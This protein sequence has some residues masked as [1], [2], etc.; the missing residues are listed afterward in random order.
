MRVTF[1]VTYTNNTI[2]K[3]RVTFDVTYTN[4]TI[5]KLL[6]CN[7]G[8]SLLLMVSAAF[9][10]GSCIGDLPPRADPPGFQ[11]L[12]EDDFTGTSLNPKYWNVLDGYVQTQYDISC[13]TADNAYVENGN[14][15]I[16]TRVQRV[17]CV[18]GGFNPTQQTKEYDYASG[19]VDTVGKVAVRNG[20]VE[21]RAKLPPPTLRIWPAGWTISDKNQRDKGPLCWPLSTEIE[22]VRNQ[23][24]NS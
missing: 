22:L 14:L 2:H 11:L 19:F 17:T 20:R 6:K 9:M 3:L 5:H 16:R 8:L 10:I 12:F 21:I 15:V 1:D 7:M 13:Y 24:Q 18:A 23:G 4:N